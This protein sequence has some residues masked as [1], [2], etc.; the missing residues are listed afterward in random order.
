MI[1]VSLVL[2]LFLAYYFEQVIQ[3]EFGVAKPWN[4]L[5][6]KQFWASPQKNKVN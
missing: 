2:T 6:T 3:S 1:L 4:F 5:F